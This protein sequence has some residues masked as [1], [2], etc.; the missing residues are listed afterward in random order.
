MSLRGRSGVAGESPAQITAATVRALGRVHSF[1][2]AIREVTTDGHTIGE[3]GAF[4]ISRGADRGFSITIS[5]GSTATS[6][7]ET[8]GS[9]YVTATAQYWL[10]AHVPANEAALLANRWI[11]MPESADPSLEQLRDITDPSKVAGC[12]LGSDT[13]PAT[14]AHRTT[15]NGMP[16][17]VLSG[18][19]VGNGKLYVSARGAPLPLFGTASGPE[20]DAGSNAPG[21]SCG[22]T[23]QATHD[24]TDSTPLGNLQAT[25]ITMTFGDYNGPSAIAPPT[26]PIL[27][28]PSPPRA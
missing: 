8:G 2:F 1:Q 22:Q 4:V 25:S 7:R 24:N 28:L 21:S 15:L 23:A 6:I 16:V 27:S 26:G 14:R 17:I 20:T 10:K 3:S 19:G 11:R 12:T 9:D 5:N 13:I 18:G